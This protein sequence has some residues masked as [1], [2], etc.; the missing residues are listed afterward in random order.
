MTIPVGIPFLFSDYS[1]PILED[2]LATVFYIF[3]ISSF[4]SIACFVSV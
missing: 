1:K 4:L 2:S 3:S